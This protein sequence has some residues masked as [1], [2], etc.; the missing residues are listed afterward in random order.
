MTHAL[1]S[2]LYRL[3]QFYIGGRFVEPAFTEAMPL[4]D[5]ASEQRVGT[6][7][8]GNESDVDR[9][10]S[11]ACEAFPGFS[12][13]PVSERI[14]LLERI[15]EVYRRRMSD[16]AD[17]ISLEMGAP[18]RLATKAQAPAGLSHIIEAANV[19]RLYESDES[20][21]TTLVTREPIGVCALITPWNWPMNQI[22]CKVAPALAAGCTVILKPSELAPLSAMLF[23]EILD[24]AG[25]PPGVFN[26]VNGTGARVGARLS[27][28]PDVD[29]ISFTGSNR[30]GALVAKAA[31]DSVKRVHQELG[32]KSPYLLLDD[33]DFTK[34]VPA[35]VRACFLNSGQSCNAPT[36]LL[37]PRDRLAEVEKLAREEAERLSIGSP[38]QEAT[39]M[40]PLV[41]EGQFKRVQSLI[42]SGKAEGARLLC[43]GTGR[44]EHLPTG[45]YV[46][47]TIF[48][49]VD[50]AMGIARG[51]IFGPVLCII[52]YDGEEEA[53]AIANDTPYGLASY[54]TS[55]DSDRARRVARQLRAGMVHI[56]GAFADFA[57]PFGGYKA[58]GNGSEWGRYGL[59]SYLEVKSIFGWSTR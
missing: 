2:T 43:G 26:L 29:M 33:A 22:G 24:E 50:N 54:V 39:F 5:P 20:I 35:A 12:S 28:H 47:P 19:L 27:G 58:S 17:A 4:V 38:R 41:S 16:M 9:A 3:G 45:Y 52:A 46:K 34:A 7:A 48:T 55:A 13:T 40:G 32:G 11:A 6:V 8:L 36:R 37:V 42:E 44:P 18:I 51:E 14:A 15:A 10:V 56:N 23:A 57:A 31:A 25:V 30:A 49:D 21:G 59:E 1:D 53:T